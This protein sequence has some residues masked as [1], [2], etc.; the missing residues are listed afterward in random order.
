[1]L[2]ESN[3]AKNQVESQ[4]ELFADLVSLRGFRPLNREEDTLLTQIEAS[5]TQKEKFEYLPP[6]ARIPAIDAFQWCRQS[7][8]TGKRNDDT[9]V[10]ILLFCRINVCPIFEEAGFLPFTPKGSDRVSG[11]ISL[12]E[13]NLSNDYRSFLSRWL[14]LKEPSLEK[15]ILKPSTRRSRFDLLFDAGFRPEETDLLHVTRKEQV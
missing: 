1:M 14:I 13:M 8:H 4:P 12:A 6:S 2:Q 9:V 7:N 5:D 10:E 11:I 15:L 3:S